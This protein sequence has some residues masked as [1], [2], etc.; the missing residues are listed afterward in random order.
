[1]GVP[2][3]SPE[4]DGAG[5]HCCCSRTGHLL[6]ATLGESAWAGRPARAYGLN[7]VAASARA[8][9]ERANAILRTMRGAERRVAQLTQL[10]Q[11]LAA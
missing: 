3:R 5:E 2:C 9:Q 7:T 11:R 6:V 8:A 4:R 10:I 1:M